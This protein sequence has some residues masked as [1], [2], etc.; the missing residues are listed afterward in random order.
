MKYNKKNKEPVKK[1]VKDSGFTI[2]E[3]LF[4]LLLISLALMSISQ[5]ITA[6][7][8]A[9]K[10]ST[11][12]F[13]MQQKIEYCRNQLASKSF[14]AAELEEGNYSTLENP[15]KINWD[16]RNISPTLK[17]IRLSVS[18][19]KITKKAYFYISKYIKNNKPKEVIK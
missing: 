4:S 13:N 14:A 2:I 3:T 8:A 10:K 11:L 19:K 5:M 6:A 1:P 15:F 12:R 7:I 18:Y 17:L 16:I 9:Q